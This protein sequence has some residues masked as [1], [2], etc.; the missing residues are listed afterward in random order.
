M[1]SMEDTMFI[2]HRKIKASVQNGFTLIEL[3]IVIAIVGIIAS[4]AI[5]EFIRYR[6]RALNTQAIS[7]LRNLQIDFEGF[8]AEFG[9]YPN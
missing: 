2:F 9:Q 6:A 3:M 7:D 1:V 8:Y 5:P 4:I